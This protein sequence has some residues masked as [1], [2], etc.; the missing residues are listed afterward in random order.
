MVRSQ[1]RWPLDQLGSRWGKTESNIH[2]WD[3]F[4]VENYG[5]FAQSL[6]DEIINNWKMKLQSLRYSSKSCYILLYLEAYYLQD[7]AD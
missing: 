2:D 4:L 7:W 1:P 5:D 3:N 6:E